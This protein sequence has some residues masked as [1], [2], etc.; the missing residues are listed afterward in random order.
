MT[1][2]PTVV[3]RGTMAPTEMSAWFPKTYGEIVAFLRTHHTMPAG[4]PFARYH[5]LPDGRF[6]VE[7]GFPVVGVVAS[8]AVTQ[9]SSL[10]G[11]TVAV[12]VHVGPYDTL[13]ENYAAVAE[14]LRLRGAKAA[15]DPWEIYRD[16]PD[17]D[18]AT[19]RTEIV[20]PYE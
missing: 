19:W 15:G 13:G 12:T 3:R 20:Q 4:P 11:G 17:G 10:P 2:Q 9:M 14:W 8:D 6:E 7:A 18:P 16:P 5:Q 1:E